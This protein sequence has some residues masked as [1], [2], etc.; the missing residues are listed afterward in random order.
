VR[1]II[2]YLGN[3]IKKN[4]FGGTCGTYGEEERFMPGFGGKIEGK[5]P[6]RRPRH[7]RENNTKI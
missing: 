7:R 1:K 3:K 5:R 2:D 4:D 6:L